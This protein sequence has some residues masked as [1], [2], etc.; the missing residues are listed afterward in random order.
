MI[1]VFGSINIDQVYQMASL[2]EPGETV[3]GTAYFQVPG[4]KGANQALA[5]R[6]AGAPVTM[7]GCVGRDANAEPALHLMREGGV[8][9][10]HVVEDSA[11]TGSASIWVDRQGENSIVVCAG[12]NGSLAAEHVPDA[13]LKKNGLL[14][15]QMETDPEENWKL[16]TR[17]K[18]RGMKTLLNLAPAGEVP[19]TALSA[20][21][22][23]IINE[24]EGRALTT[25]YDLGDKQGAALAVS[26]SD[27]F[28]L[29]CILTLG[30]KG[31]VAA[32][33]GDVMAQPAL[34]VTPVDTTAAGDSFI[35]GF[36][37]ALWEGRDLRSALRFATATAGLACT[38]A[39]AQSSLPERADIDRVLEG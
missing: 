1:V 12:A 23:L 24:G 17:A 2:P 13:V 21:D 26:L 36:A 29:C 30:G 33:D 34:E 19:K 28:N 8:N 32:R 11:P 31:V 18:A 7:I 4:G 3:L 25:Q 20:V 37:A 6:R 10:D 9:L 22:Y 14:L 35:G 16:L 15:L 5:A 27:R 38:V 39:G